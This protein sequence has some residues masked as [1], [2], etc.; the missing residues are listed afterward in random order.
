MAEEYHQDY[1][2]KNPHKME[3]ELISSGRNN[4]EELK[5]AIKYYFDYIN[6]I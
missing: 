6:I 3:E 1:S 5:Y 4:K 2:L